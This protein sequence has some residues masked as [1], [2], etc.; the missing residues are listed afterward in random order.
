MDAS[1]PPL[2]RGPAAGSEAK[3]PLRLWLRLLTCTN[4]IEQRVRANLRAQ[5]KTTL[6]RFDFLA[7]L[8]RAPDGLTM[9]EISRRLLVSP[10][11]VT[12]VAERLETEGLIT[13]RPDPHDRRTQIVR[14]T[15]KGRKRFAELAA[16]HEGWIN[17]LFAGLGRRD[18][19]NLFD[20]LDKAKQVL[21]DNT[22]KGETP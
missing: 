2:A 3:R 18:I 14:L 6:P 12:D 21:E 4:L 10:G 16:S 7:A 1:G 13:R 17:G 5:Y 8:D 22:G 20:L 9:G 11:N 19:E 15:P